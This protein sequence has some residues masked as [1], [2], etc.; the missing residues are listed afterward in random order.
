[1]L[2]VLIH[3]SFLFLIMVATQLELF[4]SSLDYLCFVF[5][6][7]WVYNVDRKGN[8]WTHFF[9][10]G[11]V[12]CEPQKLHIQFRLSKPTLFPTPSDTWA[13]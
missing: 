8:E 6:R 10:V 11:S 13:P 9:C 5:N 4:S 7:S 1:M 2:V 3:S 12:Q